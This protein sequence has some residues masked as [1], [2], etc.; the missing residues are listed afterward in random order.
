ME[1][2]IVSNINIQFQEKKI[3]LHKSKQCSHKNKNNAG[4]L[5]NGHP[6]WSLKILNRALGGIHLGVGMVRLTIITEPNRTKLLKWFGKTEPNRLK[7]GGNE[8]EPKL[9]FS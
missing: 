5:R 9:W 6:T 7:F 4:S 2:E 8:T 3:R 1:K